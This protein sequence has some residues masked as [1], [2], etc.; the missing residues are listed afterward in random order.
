[1]LSIERWRQ[2]H[3]EHRLQGT[4]R[5]Q[6]PATVRRVWLDIEYIGAR[7]TA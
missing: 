6:L 2:F 3:N 7:L 5:Y 4:H 1:M